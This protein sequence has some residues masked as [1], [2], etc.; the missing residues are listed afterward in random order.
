MESR[1]NLPKP[2][3][4]LNRNNDG[5]V[6]SLDDGSSDE[7]TMEEKPG[8]NTSFFSSNFNFQNL[9]T[10]IDD[11]FERKKNLQEI[12]TA[13]RAYVSNLKTLKLV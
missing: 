12:V 3:L 2:S 7:E 4:L 10:P 9:D 5:P 11:V 13:E 6:F 1:I 8:T